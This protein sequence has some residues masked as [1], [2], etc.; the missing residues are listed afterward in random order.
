MVDIVF[1]TPG[2]SVEGAY[3]KSLLSTVKVLHKKGITWKFVNEYSSHVS[4]AREI[5]IAVI[6]EESEGHYAPKFGYKK[7]FWIDSDMVFTPNDVLKLYEAD[8][9]VVSGC[10]LTHG[11]S[12]A[13]YSE[14]YI[15][16]LTSNLSI[17]LRTVEA[18]GFGFLALKQGVVESIPSPVFRDAST[19]LELL[20]EDL[21]FCKKVRDLGYEIWLDQDVF[22]GHVKKQIL[23]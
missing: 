11:N 4:V 3:M 20:G 15:P 13:A 19:S 1:I 8:E 5:S 14:K 7:L 9:D 22:L 21:V 10:Y 12:L 6:C 23:T 16:L 2:H 17:G 18:V